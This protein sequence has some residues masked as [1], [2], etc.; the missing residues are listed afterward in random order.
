ML[1]LLNLGLGVWGQ[2]LVLDFMQRFRDEA[3]YYQCSREKCNCDEPLAIL[4]CVDLLPHQEWKPCLQNIGHL[5]HTSNDN[6]SLFVITGT[7]LV[8]PAGQ[9]V[10]VFS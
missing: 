10:S 2:P 1:D 4:R 6:G 5:V 9:E 8:S 7:N 3:R